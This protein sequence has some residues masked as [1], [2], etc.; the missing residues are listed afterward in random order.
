M[1]VE[2]SMV[3]DPNPAMWRWSI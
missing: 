2:I 3:C 1:T